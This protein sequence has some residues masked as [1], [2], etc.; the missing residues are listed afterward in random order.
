MPAASTYYASETAEVKT[1]KMPDRDSAI[2]EIISRYMS[3]E[4]VIPLRKSLCPRYLS[5]EQTEYKLAEEAKFYRLMKLQ[6]ALPPIDGSVGGAGSAQSVPRMNAAQTGPPPT[7]LPP[8]TAPVPAPDIVQPAMPVAP[9]TPSGLTDNRPR[10]L[11]A[12]SSGPPGSY[13]SGDPPASPVPPPATVF[14]YLYRPGAYGVRRNEPLF[15]LD[16]FPENH[17]LPKL[18]VK[19][20]AA[21][22]K[23][24]PSSVPSFPYFR[25]PW[26]C[27]MP[28]LDRPVRHQM[29]TSL[30]HSVYARPNANINSC[31][32]K[33]VLRLPERRRSRSVRAPVFPS[34]PGRAL[35]PALSIS[36]PRFDYQIH[37]LTPEAEWRLERCRV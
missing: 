24:V 30:S 17:P 37:R 9:S 3:R 11:T 31:F 1:Y 8:S 29:Q 32:P 2:F 36:D 34:Y 7:V 4:N 15:P 27:H 19:A 28:I 13:T 22:I 20:T 33:Q 23:S 16:D 26:C 21:E 5:Y 10:S 25:V 12:P 14:A 18:F 35:H 6:K